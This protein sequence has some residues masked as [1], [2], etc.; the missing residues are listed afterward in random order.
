MKTI[1]EKIWAKIARQETQPQKASRKTKGQSLV[2]FAIAFPIIIILFSGVVE[3][4]FIL[5]YY[6][7]LL[8]STRESARFYANLDPFDPG[9]S[10]YAGAAAMVK[11]A[12]EPRSVNDT[13]R[14]ILLDPAA[15]DVIITVFSA[16][17]NNI[18]NYPSD[19]GYHM[20]NNDTSVFTKASMLSSR[21]SGAPNA[22]MLLVEVHYS[23]HQVLALPW[24]TAFVPNPVGMRAYT[25]MP[26]SAAEPPLNSAFAP[27]QP[28]CPP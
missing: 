17:G 22:G 23:Y 8:D 6:L 16:C 12:L 26:L 14:K 4:G 24:L 9:N 2:E 11:D 19:G 21:L 3:F 27:A 25:I 15:D 7:S 5:N 1:F 18:Y 13:T 10:F 20:Y 28:L